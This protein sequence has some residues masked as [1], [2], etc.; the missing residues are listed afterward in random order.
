MHRFI[1]YDFS[2]KIESKLIVYSKSFFHNLVKIYVSIICSMHLFLFLIYAIH[3]TLKHGDDPYKILGVR[4]DATEA[5]IK[6]AFRE[7]TKLYH[8]DV[9][10]LERKEAERKFIQCNDA[11]E[12]LTDPQRKRIYDQTG[13]VNDEPNSQ[14]DYYQNPYSFHEDIFSQFFRQST[15]RDYQTEEITSSNYEKV[16]KAN[17]E[18]FVLIYD[19]NDLFYSDQYISFFENLATEFQSHT[20]FV[21]NNLNTGHAFAVKN[22]IKSSSQL[23]AVLYL[24]YQDDQPP[25]S[26]LNHRINNRQ[27]FV[28]FMKKCWSPKFKKFKDFSKLESWINKN[29]GYTKVI[30]LIKG[31]DPDLSFYKAAS[32]YRSCKFA[33]LIDDYIAAIRKFK[34]TEFPT[35][36][37][38]RGE[39]ISPLKSFDELKSIEKPFFARI[40]PDSLENECRKCCLV[41]IG[42][43]TQQTMRNFSS[44][45]MAAT[46]W[47]PS[48][49]K[50]AQELKLS[51]G[52]MII[53]SGM[54]NKYVKIDQS[55]KISIQ[56]SSFM[57]NGLR[58]IT[59]PRGIDWTFGYA[60]IYAKE[61][62][63]AVWNYITSFNF[64][65]LFDFIDFSL[66][67]PFLFV[68]F[69]IFFRL[70]GLF[71]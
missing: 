41:H 42:Q 11:Y 2:I 49:S 57:K 70:P 68:L 5:E 44:F 46:M 17:K 13:S 3:S 18:L 6:R 31:N 51:D 30:V 48:K 60:L 32:Q 64:L 20:K 36:I 61:S 29:P 59:I 35:M 67:T 40:Q 52:E 33:V 27:S 19:G 23:P 65:S 62:I 45:T 9:S 8:P 10:K 21:R 56:I 28:S 25:I 71:F 14:Q 47:I 58:K 43:P 55:K 15:K 38:I 50:F 54:E 69:L 37:S 63:L 4:R 22:G 1:I 53:I 16:L 7:K 34:L 66:F 12:L 24:R 26:I 39:T